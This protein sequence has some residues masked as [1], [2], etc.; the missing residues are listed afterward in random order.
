MDLAVQLLIFLI[1]T[2]SAEFCSIHQ[3][4]ELAITNRILTWDSP[5]NTLRLEK[6]VKAI[7][8]ELEITENE[9]QTYSFTKGKKMFNIRVPKDTSSITLARGRCLEMKARSIT[10]EE[11]LNSKLNEKFKRIDSINFVMK[12]S[13]KTKCNIK[14]REE[15]ANC[16]KHIEDL[17]NTYKIKAN[18]TE[19]DNFL[20]KHKL[21]MLSIQGENLILTTGAQT[22]LPCITENTNRAK[23]TKW[24][25]LKNNYLKPKM[26]KV[27]KL[28]KLIQNTMKSED[29][30]RTKR[31]LFSSIFG[32]ASA[33]ET[34][35]LRTALKVELNNQKQT[36]KAMAELLRNQVKAAEEIN[37]E[38][39][40]L[41]NLGHEEAQLENKVRDL[42]T[43]LEKAF[44][45]SSEITSRL[46]QDVLAILKTVTV[47]ERLN[48]IVKQLETILDILHCPAGDCRRILEDIM[49]KEN[50]G[51]PKTYD[52][53]ARMVTVK[54]EKGH[55]Q[56]RLQNITISDPIMTVK[57]I[58]NNRAM[59]LE[60]NNEVAINKKG[61]YTP[62]KNCMRESNIILCP[63]E[64]IYHKDKCLE[65]M[66][67]NKTST[68]C[69]E[70]LQ[71]DNETIQD[72]ISNEQELQIYSRVPDKMTMKTKTFQ[73]ETEMKKGINSYTLLKEQEYQ[74]ETSYISFE[75]KNS[76]TDKILTSNTIESMYPDNPH[77]DEHIDSEKV[78]VDLDELENIVVPR[79]SGTEERPGLEIPGDNLPH[80]ALI[81]LSTPSRSWYIWMIIGMITTVIVATIIYCK[82]KKTCLFKRKERK[83]EDIELQDKES[84][85]ETLIHKQQPKYTEMVIKNL[86]FTKEITFELNGRTFYWDGL[87]WRDEN[88]V[89]QPNFREPPSYLTAELHSY[90]DGCVIGEKDS[91]PYIHLKHFPETNFNKVR[92]VFEITMNNKTR[93]LPHYCAPKPSVDTLQ[94]HTRAILEAQKM[95]LNSDLSPS[96]TH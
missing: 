47:N 15:E 43:F 72:F 23:K 79:F 44:S 71:K 28:L 65:D 56:V 4:G 3:T 78:R 58:P 2:C 20:N 6:Q 1:S 13:N 88:N 26:K 93:T 90:K 91:R 60:Y 63:E 64:P 68:N 74:I 39:D 84:E 77:K 25:V 76:V 17:A 29:G 96:K 42:K 45:N 11:V 51:E 40:I 7:Q 92:N 38:N 34:E 95:R 16:L 35:S 53:I 75:V 33:S 31:S 27:E 8:K 49:R 36:N 86:G 66:M 80:P 32:L 37:K 85:S 54:H 24:T 9:Y 19:M 50:I 62:K 67:T 89:L 81:Y 94:K 55:I 14:G 87:S 22:I 10:V 61:F 59:K 30:R 69:E 41:F 57:C 70:K 18:T 83:R 82:C 52:M 21:G 48:N 12:T 73:F 46:K 5:V